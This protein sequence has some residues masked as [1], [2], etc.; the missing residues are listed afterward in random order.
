MAIT[1]LAQFPVGFL[2]TEVGRGPFPDIAHASWWAT[3]LKLIDLLRECVVNGE[4]GIRWFGKLERSLSGPIDIFGCWSIS[5]EPGPNPPYEP[6][7][8]PS[9]GVFFFATD[10][11]IDRAIGPGTNP[12]LILPAINF[13]ASSSVAIPN[14]TYW[15][16]FQSPERL[17]RNGGHEITRGLKAPRATAFEVPSFKS[18]FIR[19]KHRNMDEVSIVRWRRTTKGL[20]Y[21]YLDQIQRRQFWV[22]LPWGMKPTPALYLEI[23]E[24][25]PSLR[26]QFTVMD[27]GC[28]TP[29]GSY[30]SRCFFMASTTLTLV[31]AKYILITLRR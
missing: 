28:L 5:A 4:G 2:P 24:A 25:T 17:Y 29:K 26:C 21:E 3:R 18:S 13:T 1:T 31:R 15:L 14:P 22:N 6:E 20:M 23:G 27:F 8:P 19:R 7:R 11:A 9:L 30:V 12:G 16:D 10:S